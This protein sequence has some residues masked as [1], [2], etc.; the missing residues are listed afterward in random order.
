MERREGHLEG[1]RERR[2][3][4]IKMRCQKPKGVKPAKM[5]GRES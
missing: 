4:L 1:L 2:S 3:H 5:E